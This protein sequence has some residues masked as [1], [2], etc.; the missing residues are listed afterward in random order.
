MSI[1]GMPD[2]RAG[3]AFKEIRLAKSARKES[4]DPSTRYTALHRR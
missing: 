3:N 2:S 4:F 1:R